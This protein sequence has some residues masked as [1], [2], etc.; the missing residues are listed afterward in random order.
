MK[1]AKGMRECEREVELQETNPLEKHKQGNTTQD[2][3]YW[4]ILT[5]VKSLKY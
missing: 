2:L 1:K 5:M 3:C 4:C